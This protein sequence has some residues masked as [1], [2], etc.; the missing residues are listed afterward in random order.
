MKNPLQPIHWRSLSTKTKSRI[1][2]KRKTW[3]PPAYPQVPSGVPS[4][5]A[6]P[7]Y[8]YKLRNKILAGGK[9]IH[10]GNNV[11]EFKNRT[12]RIWRPNIKVKALW[13]EALGRR[14]RLR[15]VTSVLRTIDRVGGLDAYLT[16]STRTRM[17]ELGPRG[18]EIR[19]AV[20]KSLRQQERAKYVLMFKRSLLLCPSLRMDSTWKEIRPVVKHT[21]GYAVL[22]EEHCKKAFRGLMEGLRAGRRGVRRLTPIPKTIVLGPKQ[23]AK[24]VRNANLGIKGRARKVWKSRV[25]APMVR[26]A[27]TQ[28]KGSA[29]QRPIIPVK[30][31]HQK[32]EKKVVQKKEGKANGKSKRRL[33]AQKRKD[34]MAKAK[35]ANIER[36]KKRKAMLS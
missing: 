30:L 34:R 5:A 28:S 25:L 32:A 3:V 33:E 35:K 14:V 31:Q 21:E 17:K 4:F 12:R 8:T 20:I 10:F 26:F 19:S 2:I 15:M 6:K 23:E 11:S 27:P 29:L 36:R 1:P 13:S 18:W 24:F 9:T 7:F 16:C 22:P